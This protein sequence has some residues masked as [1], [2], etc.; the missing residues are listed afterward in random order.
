MRENEKKI[1]D[2]L[3]PHMDADRADRLISMSKAIEEYLHK[4]K[5]DPPDYSQNN[6]DEFIEVSDN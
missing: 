5:R 2:C 3:L 1:R 6:P 4:K